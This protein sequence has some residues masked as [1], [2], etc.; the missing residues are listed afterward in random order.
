VTEPTILLA[1][2]LLLCL[3][4]AVTGS[5]NP[6]QDLCLRVGSQIA[7][8]MS[9]WEDLCCRGLGYVSLGDTFPTS[10]FPEQDIIR[11][12]QT[13]CAPVAWVQSFKLGIIRCVPVTSDVGDASFPPPTCAQWTAAAYQNMYDSASL[14]RAV[15]CFR[16]WLRAQT[17]FFL[18][19]SMVIERQVQV[20]P[21]GGCVERFV[22][23]SVEFPNCDC[24][25]VSG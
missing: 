10:N 16:N 5:P 9:Q 23:L 4:Q 24:A 17:G 2:Q 25:S 12:A 14:R 6:P 11:Q 21:N 8:D 1:D 22:T 7:H 19:M 18:D 20:D 13:P 3:S 15:C